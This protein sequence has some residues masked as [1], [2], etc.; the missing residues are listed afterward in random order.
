[1][2]LPDLLRSARLA[3]PTLAL[4]LAMGAPGAQ[5]E[6]TAV[7]AL[8]EAARLADRGDWD[9]A[10]ARAEDGGALVEQVIEWRRLRDTAEG[11][12]LDYAHFVGDN[13]DWPG[14]DRLR[15]NGE[16]AILPGTAPQAVVAFFGDAVPQTGE[17][18]V[19][20][21]QALEA[22]GRPDEAR[23]VVTDAWLTLRLTDEGQAELLGAY[24]DALVGLH[25][26]R[27]EAML[28]RW[29]SSDAE[30]MLP[31]L[32]NGRKA[33]VRAR[34]A[35]IRGNRPDLDAVPAALRNDPGLAYDRYNHLAEDGDYEEALA[36]LQARSSSAAALGQPFRWGAWRAQI[37]RW[38]LREGRSEEAYDLAAHHFIEAPTEAQSDVYADLEWLA[39]F[40]ALRRLD[41]AEA[42]IAHFRASEAAVT[43]PI[44][45]SRAA[46]W[47]GRAEEAMGRPDDAALSF[48]RAARHQTAFYGL[49]AAERLGLTLDASLTGAEDF[50]DW[51]G[52]GSRI[53]GPLTQAMLLLMSAGERDDALLFALGQA[54]T[55]PREGVGQLANLLEEMHEPYIGVLVGKAAVERGIVVPAAYFPL[56]PM[57][58][59]D[60]PVEAD[61]ALS[62]ARRESEFNAGVSSPV[63]AQGLMQLMPATAR[64]VSG[65]LGLPYSQSRLTDWEYN[66]ALGTRYLAELQGMFGTSPVLIAAGYNAGPGRP[67][68]WMGVRGDP[69]E[70]SVDVV[71]WVEM[72]PFAETRTYVMRV[73]ESIPVYRARLT[74]VAGPVQFTALLRGERPLIRPVSRPR[75]MNAAD[76]V[77]VETLSTSSVA[78][79]VAE[80]VEREMAQ[81]MARSPLRPTARPDDL[82]QA[83]PEG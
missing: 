83:A 15:A 16:R 39:G 40:A 32:D 8:R 25:E 70:P 51:R 5:A 41:D 76:L 55:L 22:L 67:R 80:A 18:A 82:A 60:W 9:A 46:Y 34:L 73:A 64:E 61:L 48:A 81:P 58:G 38:L 52:E 29:R 30:R 68:Q 36:I 27:T 35:L 62:I 33:L 17:G 12:F 1:M 69:R 13:P 24:G 45:L 11:D 20:L 59:R 49:L 54:R 4:A 71:D 7:A 37:V 78:T 21:A 65:W 23:A 47:T 72:I 26:E 63:G 50:G 31:L 19:A 42:A 14:L 10:Q 56:H 57:A 74:G 77:P 75:V 28:W 6:S 43:G 3:L 53:A 66:A 44:S 2:R 79:E